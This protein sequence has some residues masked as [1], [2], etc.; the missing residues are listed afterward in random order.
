MQL[1]QSIAESLSGKKNENSL[2]MLS[3]NSHRSSIVITP[4]PAFLTCIRYKRLSEAA[5]KRKSINFPL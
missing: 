5:K 1:E 4:I 2:S 3:T